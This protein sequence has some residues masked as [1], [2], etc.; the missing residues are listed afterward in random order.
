MIC[1]ISSMKK[2]QGNPDEQE[3][4]DDDNDEFDV[5]TPDVYDDDAQEDDVSNTE[6]YWKKL[7]E[8]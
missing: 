4:V 2:N 7:D 3:S 6:V 5:Y 8:I 1:M